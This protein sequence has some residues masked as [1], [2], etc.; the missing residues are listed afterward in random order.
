MTTDVTT[1]GRPLAVVTGA[2]Q[3]IGLELA[4]QFAARGYDL[5]VA[6]EDESI[7]TVGPG[8]QST[9]ATVQRVR[10]D[11][12]APDGVEA[13]YRHVLGTGRPV[14][15]IAINAGVGVGGDFAR[16]TDLDAE[17]RLIDFNV[18][19]SVHLAKRVAGPMVARGSGRILFTGSIAGTHPGPFE[20]VYAASKAFLGSFSG[21]LREELRDTGVT[22]TALLPGPTATNFFHRA[23]MEDTAVGSGPQDSAADVARQ[24]IEALLAG[25]EYVVTGAKNKAV[26]AAAKVLPDTAAARAHRSM[27]EPGS[28][29]Q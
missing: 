19:S 3:G 8:W 1:T 29:T 12:A 21:A 6:A 14:D 5:V 7:T 15:A 27:S 20:A 22:V 24:G 4:D 17:L 28:G 13:L 11:L 2:S 10:V 26:A 16:D 18:R 9:C 25:E 23:G